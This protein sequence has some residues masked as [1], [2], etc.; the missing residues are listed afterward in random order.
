MVKVTILT[1][2]SCVYCPTA[3]RIWAEVKKEKDFDYEEVDALS[4]KGQQI[5]ERYGIMSVP[6]TLIEK[7]G[8][9]EVAF[10]GVPDKQKAISKVA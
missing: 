6:T 8:R 10:V 2:K 3:K 1:T 5:V 7:N 9:T 4:E